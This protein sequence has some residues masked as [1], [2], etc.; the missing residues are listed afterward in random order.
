MK[1]VSVIPARGGSKGI[2]FKNLVDINGKPLIWYSINTSLNSCVDETWVSTNDK[3]IEKVSLE[4]GAHVRIRPD[5]LCGDVIMPDPS[6]LH[7]SESVEFDILVFIQPTSPLIKFEYINSAI[8]KLL[9]NDYAS[10]FSVCREHWLPRWDIGGNPVNWDIYKRPRRQDMK[11]LFI[12]NGMFYIST[13]ECLIK[14]QLRYGGN[15]GLFEV[16]IYDSF[17]VDSLEDLELIRRFI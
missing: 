14:N 15:I 11:E 13:R 6:L 1:I 8:D 16:P 17:Q 3:E 10:I 9:W 5:Y 12:E 2:P 4:L 7:F